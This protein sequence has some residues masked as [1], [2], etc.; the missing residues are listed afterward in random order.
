LLIADYTDLGHLLCCLFVVGELDL[1]EFDYSCFLL[2][3]SRTNKVRLEVLNIISVVA[4]GRRW[5][6]LLDL[7]L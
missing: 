4:L 3:K 7:A 5:C 2:L 6:H 1:V